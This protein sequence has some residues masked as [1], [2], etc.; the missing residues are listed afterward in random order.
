MS[1]IRHFCKL[2]QANLLL[3]CLIRCPCRLEDTPLFENVKIYIGAPGSPTAANAG[4]YVD[5]S[6]LGTIIQQTRSTYSS[7][8]GMYNAKSHMNDSQKRMMAVNS[9]SNRR[10]L[11]GCATLPWPWRARLGA[12]S[13][14]S[15]DSNTPSILVILSLSSIKVAPY[16]LGASCCLFPIT[17]RNKK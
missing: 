11:S 15:G 14:Q 8:G 6:T 1:Y 2:N 13:V 3:R 9:S 16:S 4:S 12:K 17:H 10:L 5:S 7:F